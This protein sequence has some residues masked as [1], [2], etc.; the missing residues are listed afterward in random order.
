MRSSRRIRAAGSDAQN[1]RGE[2]EES[3]GDERRLNMR[4]NEEKRD[5]RRS[6]D[7]IR[8]K[9]MKAKS[10]VGIKQREETRERKK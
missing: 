4:R 3:V 7:E 1:V 2:M 8:R 5:G 10:D 9:R 6:K